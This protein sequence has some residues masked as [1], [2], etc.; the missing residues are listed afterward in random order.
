MRDFT[1]GLQ[2][3]FGVQAK[4]GGGSTTTT[5]TSNYTPEQRQLQAL[6]YQNALAAQPLFKEIIS[7]AASSGNNPQYYP[8]QTVAEFN[9]VQL[10]A[11][12]NAINTAQNIGTDLNPLVASSLQFGLTDAM[13]PNPYLQEYM[14]IQEDP[15][16]DRFQNE[17][18]PQI[19]TAASQQGAFGGV[20]QGLAKAQATENLARQVGDMRT[21]LA[22]QGYNQGLNTFGNTLSQVGNIYDTLQTPTNILANV[23]DT[24]QAQ[25]QSQI[26]AAIDR[27]NFMQNP[28]LARFKQYAGILA[29]ASDVSGGGSQLPGPVSQTAQQSS[30]SGG[31]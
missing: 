26:N 22:F 8:G 1:K 15:L 23:G 29:A 9:P 27:F 11:Q 24:L 10:A 2:F 30:K 7:S 31:K 5:T 3:R 25:E 20:R 28:D 18:I 6:S 17:I 19:D 16:V 4:G 14:R 21:S 12:A 13:G